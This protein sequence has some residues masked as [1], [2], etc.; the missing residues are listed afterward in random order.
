[1]KMLNLVASAA[2]LAVVGCDCCTCGKS[3]K[4]VVVSPDGRNE[5]RLYSNPLSYEVRRDGVVVVAKTDIGMK[6]NDTC[7]GQAGTWDSVTSSEDRP[8]EK[9][10]TPVYKKSAIDLSRNTKFFNFGGK[11]G[12]E[13]VAR[14]DG[15]AYRFRTSM[16]GEIKVSCEKAPLTLPS[17]DTKCWANRSGSFGCEETVPVSVVASELKTTPPGK[18]NQTGTSHVYLPFGYSVGGKTVIVTESDVENY[19]IWNFTANG[20]DSNGVVR[21]ESVFAQAP[22]ATQRLAGWGEKVVSEGGRWVKIVETEDFLVSCDG[23]RTFPWRT[24]ILA[25]EPSKVCE[26]DIVYAL[27][28]P[29]AVGS[30]FSWVKPGKVAWDWWNCFDNARLPA[31]GGCNTQTYERFIDFAQKTGIEYVIFDEGWS[32]TLNIWKFHP[33]V[34][35]P[36]LIKYANDRGVGIILWMAW[37]QVYGSEE[38]VAEHFA[39]LGA[40]GFKVDFMDRG[41]AEMENFLRDFAAACAKSRMIV[42]YHG[43][44]R[45]TGLQREFP[46]VVNYEGIHGLEQL[47]W[48]PGGEKRETELMFSDVAAFFL[49]LSAGPMDYTPGAM[50]NHAV[51]AGYKGNGNFP[52]SVGTR[53]RQMAM[54]ALYEAPLQMLCDSPTNYEKNMESFG[55]MSKV[56]VVWADTVGLGGCPDTLVAAARQAKDGSWYAAGMTTAKASDFTVDTKFLDAAGTWKAEI[57]RDAPESVTD[58]TKY[59]REEKTV[60]AGD[61]LDFHMAPGGGFIVK[62]TR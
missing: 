53:C 42:D 62:F 21:L 15:V 9:L 30:D 12:V 7:L 28:K 18:D 20:A 1:M 51:G 17:K 58:G 23:T 29:A 40:K 52:G 26:A 59:V 36:H 56:P 10:A 3:P 41:D 44:C 8:A 34:D 19:P 31:N 39:K 55:F 2:L 32:E 45:P 35:V 6:V 50:L 48:F 61:K 4:D 14:N 57:F 24:F 49:R 47:K 16:D 22:K 43:V 27:A 5:I 54:M 60:T 11:W 46:N 38:K 33:D 13:L 25:D 37:A